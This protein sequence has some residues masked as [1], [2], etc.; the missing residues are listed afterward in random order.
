MIS[1][2]VGMDRNRVIGVDNKLPWHLPADLAFFKRTTMG[3]PIVMG[4]KTFESIGKALPGRE[5]VILTR[6]K[7]YEKE[8]CTI[9]HSVDDVEKFAEQTEK[10]V[11][12][13][14]GTEIFKQTFAIADRLYI[15]FIDEEFTGDTFFPEFHNDEWELVSEEKG[16]KDEKNPYDYY[17]RVYDRKHS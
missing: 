17:F 7:T 8:G 6:D 16:I 3:N 12:I 5:N 13:I 15:T 11:F 1:F 10:E 9:I 4:R 14:G 2:I